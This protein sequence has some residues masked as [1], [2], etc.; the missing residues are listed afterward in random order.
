[1][2]ILRNQAVKYENKYGILCA[3]LDNQKKREGVYP[4]LCKIPVG[5]STI[6]H[7]HFEPE[8]FYI[9]EGEATLSI[10][11]ESTPVRSG[12]LVRIPASQ[13]HHLQNRGGNELLFLSVYSEDTEVPALFSSV[14][15]TAAPPTP[16]GPLHLG[17]ISGPYLA[18]D[19]LR[20]HL[21]A[22]GVSVVSHAGTDDHQ[23]Y[24]FEKALIQ[25]KS[26]EEFRIQMRERIQ[27]GLEALNIEFN[28]FI[29]P[30]K[31]SEYQNRVLN[32]VECAIKSGSVYPR[33][34][35]FPYCAHC[36]E[37]LVDARISAHCPDCHHPSSG[38]CENCGI[39]T[40][41][42]RL[43]Q[44]HCSRCQKPVKTKKSTAYFFSLGKN[45]RLISAELREHPLP[46]RLKELLQKVAS[47]PDIEVMVT[48]P[49]KGN[50]A[51]S[52]PCDQGQKIH[53]WLEMAAH[54]ES[55]AQRPD[56]WIHCFGFD[57][58]FY[59]LLFIPAI[60]RSLNPKTRLPDVFVSNE[61]FLL[62]G[63]KFST[64]RNHAIWADEFSGNTDH[65]RLFLSLKRP[66]VS[67]SNFSPE[68]FKNFSLKLEKQLLSLK[69]RQLE[70][71]G[72]VVDF[73]AGERVLRDMELDLHPLRLDLRSASRK[74]LNFLDQCVH[75]QGSQEN[76][77]YRLK[78]LA[79]LLDPF[80]P[81]EA[82]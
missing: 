21:L 41:A 29:E 26:S 20:R 64:S 73:S 13:T 14:L 31:D 40:S 22:E 5:G 2:N 44:P 69:A 9:I 59:Y 46:L 56:F 75:F 45:L 53:V 8:I 35:D 28:E 57:N 25:K 49:G 51:L 55:L 36:E 50:E 6:A 33:K 24:V 54:Y 34:V 16:N 60:L 17:H 4:T 77:L 19:I 81:N 23:N 12:D 11:T 52:L 79:R 3:P 78:T 71:T 7:S 70:P 42:D 67:Q 1:M 72:E 82:Y 37:F 47:R 80:M 43:L 58:S 18:A 27:N 10:G 61:F 38:A 66:S 48:Y 62:Q 74:I 15:I 76:F 39:V 65:L 32:F 63:S 30:R 68:E